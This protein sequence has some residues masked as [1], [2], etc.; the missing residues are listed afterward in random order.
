[1][2]CDM[3]IPAMIELISEAKSMVE[4]ILLISYDD[5]VNA[6]FAPRRI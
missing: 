1:M 4:K 2:V 6:Y 5:K 3:Q